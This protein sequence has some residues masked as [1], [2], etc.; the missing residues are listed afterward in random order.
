[1]ALHRRSS[2][3]AASETSRQRAT[4]Q[5]GSGGPGADDPFFDA[6]LCVAARLLEPPAAISATAARTARDRDVLCIGVLLVCVIVCSPARLA[7]VAGQRCI[8][9][10]CVGSG[11]V[12]GQP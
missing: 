4:G 5:R 8:R 1:M 12:A 2:V 6:V 3:H 11:Y 9:G 10:S 7:S